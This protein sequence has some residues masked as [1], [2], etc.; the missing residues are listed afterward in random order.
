M[1]MLVS[2]A[3]VSTP[4]SVR[5][6]TQLCKHFEHKLPVSYDKEHGRIE[7]ESGVCSISAAPDLLALR[8]EASD[9]ERLGRVENV[10][11][12]HLER[13]AFRDQPEIRWTRL[14]A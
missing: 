8:A 13:F 3:R 2:E 6:M 5:Y 1:T 4:M 9:E 12:R 10:V 7:F 11:V 14:G